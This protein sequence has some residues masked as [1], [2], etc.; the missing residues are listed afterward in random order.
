MC[1]ELGGVRRGVTFT[2][3]SSMWTL[4]ET[5][6]IKKNKIKSHN[7]TMQ[8]IDEVGASQIYLALR[9]F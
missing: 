7:V 5:T 1:L 8:H 2:L 4:K 9:L 3:Y 6:K